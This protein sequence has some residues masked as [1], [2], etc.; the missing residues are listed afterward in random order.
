VPRK[1]AARKYKAL[2]LKR[3]GL[4]KEVL[5][6]SRKIFSPPEM[7]SDAKKFWLTARKKSCAQNKQ[8][9]NV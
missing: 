2:L 5:S 9:K 6:L 8:E 4:K 3:G 7:V 1:K